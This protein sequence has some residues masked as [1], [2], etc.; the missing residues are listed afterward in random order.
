MDKNV[1]VTTIM[2]LMSGTLTGLCL[3]IKRYSIFT[4]VIAIA[5][6]MVTTIPQPNYW[7]SEQNGH[8][9]VQNRKPLENRYHW[10]TVQRATARIPNAFSIPVPTVCYCVLSVSVIK[11]PMKKLCFGEQLCDCLDLETI[12]FSFQ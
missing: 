3:Y 8:P 9:F 5:L 7:K 10:K 12:F 6:A 2:F 11:L 4:I 1:N